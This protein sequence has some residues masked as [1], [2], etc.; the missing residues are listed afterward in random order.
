MSFDL[1]SVQ[2]MLVSFLLVLFRTAGLVMTAPMLGGALA[3][4]RARLMLALALALV[5]LPLSPA[6]ADT[7]FSGRLALHALAETAIGIGLGLVLQLAFEALLLAGE[8]I[9]SGSGLSFAQ[10]VDPVRGT[11]AAAVG[12]LFTVLAMLAFLAQDGHLAVVRLLADSFRELPLSSPLPTAALT[13]LLIGESARMFAGA[14]Q[15]ALPGMIA[16]LAVNLALGVASR[17]APALNLFSVGLPLSVLAGLLVL[18]LGVQVFL[19]GWLG[20]AGDS[21]LS[22]AQVWKP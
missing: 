2:P 12:S 13:Q 10:L 21:L 16:L 19:H 11:S 20:V 5:L 8:A 22:A 3:G 15:V 6:P 7:A 1:A 18:F 4:A 17:A 14:L 9:S